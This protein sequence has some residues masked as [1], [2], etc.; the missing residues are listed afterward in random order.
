MNFKISII[1]SLLPPFKDAVGE[2][3][4]KLKELLCERG[5]SCSIITSENQTNR[6]GVNNVIKN[7]NFVG[8][9]SLIKYVRKAQISLSYFSISYPA[10]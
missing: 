2:S 8:V 1:C 6:D 10:L 7:W 3:A 5:Y 4:L 9:I